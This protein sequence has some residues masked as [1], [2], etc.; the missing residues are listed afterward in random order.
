MVDDLYVAAAFFILVG[1]PGLGFAQAQT[2][3]EEKKSEI[4]VDIDSD[5]Q[6]VLQVDYRHRWDIKVDD[7][8]AVLVPHLSYR[9][10]KEIEVNLENAYIRYP[11]GVCSFYGGEKAVALSLYYKKFGKGFF[12]GVTQENQEGFWP[13]ALEGARTITAG[14]VIPQVSKAGEHDLKWTYTNTFDAGEGRR[15]QILSLEDERKFQSGDKCRY[16]FSHND[17]IYRG[18]GFVKYST[19]KLSY[20]QLV[21]KGFTIRWDIGVAYNHDYDSEQNIRRWSPLVEV[22]LHMD[23]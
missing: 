15:Y 9:Q 20:E 8:E 23:L 3:D 5:S 2:K 18:G 7:V 4:S 16:I 19:F 13:G 17:R 22:K 1:I 21:R 6:D 12:A 11:M 14:M 10:D